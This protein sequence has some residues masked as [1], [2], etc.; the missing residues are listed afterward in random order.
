MGG[1]QNFLSTQ[2][3]QRMKDQNEKASELPS[4][5]VVEKKE[6]ITEKNSMFA[7]EGER[8]GSSEL[9]ENVCVSGRFAE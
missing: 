9:K 6:L 3:S 4:P 5:D 2:T 1:P 8:R 7:V